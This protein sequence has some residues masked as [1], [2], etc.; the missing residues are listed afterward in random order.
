[1]IGYSLK[2]DFGR[3]HNLEISWISD[4]SIYNEAPISHWK[5][6]QWHKE[7]KEEKLIVSRIVWESELSELFV[8]S[9]VSM[10]RCLRISRDYREYI[11]YKIE[12]LE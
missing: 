1:M 8:A 11:I 12:T 3:S 10:H 4:G 5:Q 9:V 6:F 7:I 2:L